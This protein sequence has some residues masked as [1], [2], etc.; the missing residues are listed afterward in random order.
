MAKSTLSAAMGV[1]FLSWAM[2]GMA[3]PVA[4][5]PV[6]YS[7]PSQYPNQF[8]GITSQNQGSG[9]N[10]QSF[11][12]FTLAAAGTIQSITWQGLYW[13]FNGGPNPAP[14]NTTSFQIGFFANVNN[15]PS[16]NPVSGGGP[17]LLT[18]VQSAVVG[19]ALFEGDTVN[20]INFSA[21]L[22][23]AF[24]A[25][26]NTTYWLSI[27]S[28]AN[29]Y[30]P[31][32]LWTSGTGGDGTSAQLNYGAPNPVYAVGDRAFSLS[33]SP[34]GDLVVGSPPPNPPIGQLAD[35]IPEP[36]TLSLAGIAIVCFAAFRFGGRGHASSAGSRRMR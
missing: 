1:L 3:R 25:Q 21:N 36:G 15:Q 10:W 19:T 2:F 24:T 6:L 22:Q 13:N 5:G 18:G 32:W 33:A 7:Q 28:F 12:D 26:A 16:A 31:A 29:S 14:P 30:P 34:Q 35:A 20:V 8:N 11:D 23:T 17:I 9:A 4:A 27:V